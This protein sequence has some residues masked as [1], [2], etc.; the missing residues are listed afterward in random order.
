MSILG[1]LGP[2]NSIN[3]NHHPGT[4][5]T[6][7][8]FWQFLSINYPLCRVHKFWIRSDETTMKHIKDGTCSG[9][10]AS[11]SS[12]A[13]VNAAWVT[14]ED[15]EDSR[16]GVNVNI[17][18]SQI[19]NYCT[20]DYSLFASIGLVNFYWICYS[21]LDLFVCY[22]HGFTMNDNK[23]IHRHSLSRFSYYSQHCF[24]MKVAFLRGV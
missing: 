22:L 17:G 4:S 3:G 19:P 15:G 20:I 1:H 16:I 12:C 9:G 18:G 6:F 7:N 13:R 14:G 2:C 23:E 8:G 5:P 21:L 24:T 11:S 10:P